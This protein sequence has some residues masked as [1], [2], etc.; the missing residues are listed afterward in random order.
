MQTSPVK[1]SYPAEL[2]E[3]PF[4]LAQIKAAIPASCFEP[5]VWKSLSYFFLDVSVISILYA[6][7]YYLNSWFFWPIFWLMQGT[8]FWALF[9]VG[10]DCGHGSFS[11]KKWLND[12][13]GHLS[14]TPILVPYHGW[15]ISH[16][17][18]HQNTGNIDTDESWY[19]VTESK[20]K[21]MAWW[22]KYLRFDLALLFVYPLYLFKRSPERPGGSHF[23]PGSPLFK[24][25]E[26]W[27]VLTST[28]C[29]TLMIGLLGFLTYE[30]GWM[31]LVKYYLGPYVVFVVWLDLVTFLHHTDP[32][33]PWYR[34]K[35]WYFLKGA[36]STI[37][38]DYGFINNIHHNIGTHV[39]HH[40]FLNMPHYH[41]KTATEAIKPILGDYYRKSE[42]SVFSAFLRSYKTC[43]FVK[44]TGSKVYYTPK[45]ELEKG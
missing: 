27:D 16:R 20:Y 31:W 23:H 19:P 38:H 45:S 24:P 6:A 44:D 5:S 21:Q 29:L 37:D 28:A 26:K 30:W 25:S 3:P 1:L 22:E 12:L 39:A 13:I 8:M 40:I 17:T 14:H 11:K 33:I 34:G 35:D 7:A 36:L 15:R 10:H 42:R 9:V 4:T 41:L 18:H 2:A 32:E 43:H